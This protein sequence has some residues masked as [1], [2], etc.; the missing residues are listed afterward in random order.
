MGINIQENPV[1]P[2]EYDSWSSKNLYNPDSLVS[3]E[4]YDHHVLFGPIIKVNGFLYIWMTRSFSCFGP[5][6][7]FGP[8]GKDDH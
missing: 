5:D 3:S 1:H 7:T 6:Q 4:Q 8:F 2:L